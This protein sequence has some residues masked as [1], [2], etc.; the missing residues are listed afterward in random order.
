MYNKYSY[1]YF[2]ERCQTPRRAMLLGYG[3][4][5]LQPNSEGDELRHREIV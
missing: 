1:N 2:R 5:V 3:L 4:F